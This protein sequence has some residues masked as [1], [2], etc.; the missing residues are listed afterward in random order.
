MLVAPL[1]AADHADGAIAIG[2][3]I[4]IGVGVGDEPVR[5]RDDRRVAPSRAT[6]AGS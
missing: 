5:L 4:G 1:S 2:I 3:G 6:P